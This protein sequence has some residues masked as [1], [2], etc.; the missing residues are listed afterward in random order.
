MLQVTLH[1]LC[2]TVASQVRL[3]SFFLSMPLCVCVLVCV[4]VSACVRFLAFLFAQLFVFLV[5]K[6]S[7]F[8]L[9]FV[10]EATAGVRTCVCVREHVCMYEYARY[11]VPVCVCVSVLLQ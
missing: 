6:D 7:V 8:V 4:F 10:K 3:S 11:S 2:F 9:T 1:F 5:F